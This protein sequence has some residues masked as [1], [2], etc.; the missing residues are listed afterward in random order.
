MPADTHARRFGE[1]EAVS[2]S[3]ITVELDIDA[4]HGVALG[5]GVPLRFPRVNSIV[6]IP[7]EDGAVV[8]I[9][10]AI[11]IVPSSFPKRTGLK[12]YGVVDLPF[13]SR[14][15]DITP[16]GVLK[17]TDYTEAGQ[18]QL[19]VDR[20]VLTPPT[21]GSPVL[22]PTEEELSAVL[23]GSTGGQRVEIGTAALARELRVKVDPD[24]LFGR[25]VAVLGNTGSGKSCTVSGLIRWNLD[26]ARA[27]TEAPNARFVVL[28][29]NGEYVEA[30]RDLA[31]VRVFRAEPDE[32]SSQLRVPAWL[33]NASEWSAFSEASRGVQRPLLF[34][35]LR[36]LRS[37]A[38]VPDEDPRKLSVQVHGY[39]GILRAKLNQ[40][41]PAYAE[42]PGSKNIGEQLQVMIETF[43]SYE[44]RVPEGTIKDQLTEL[45]E[46]SQAVVTNHLNN[47]GFWSAFSEPELSGVA[48]LL[49]TLRAELPAMEV[50]AGVSEDAPVPFDSAEMVAHL[51]VL[52]SG[53]HQASQFVGSF[54]LRISTMLSHIRM[55]SVVGPLSDAA[56]D[57]EEGGEGEGEA[58]ETETLEGWLSDYLA[59]SD[60]DGPS[61]VIVDLSLVPT[62]L[63]HIVAG[64]ISRVLFE[65]LQRYRRIRGFELPT[66]LVVE[67]AHHF[68]HRYAGHEHG[69]PEA[70]IVCRET[71]ETI[72]REG[73]KFGLGMVLSSQRPSEVSPTV[74]SQCNTFLLH[75]IVNDR[76]QEL[77]KRL[78]PDNLGRMLDDLPSLPT[79]HAVLLGWATAVPILM[80]VKTLPP[81]QRPR[82]SD[83]EFWATWSRTVERPVSWD[84]IAEQWRSGS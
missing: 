2:A 3:S 29:P 60:D 64:V 78:V 55:K 49:E 51:E 71:M 23:E 19:V 28:D 37:G 79:Q 68:V 21:V 53:Q 69:A 26:A 83:P 16:L 31:S 48:D 9:V 44:D 11:R 39:L 54:G 4:P 35:A 72:A 24:R 10:H 63:M 81:E 80:R 27:T 67:E 45:V 56:K 58:D 62:S 77:V 61:V 6:V 70:A 66:V 52:A 43:Q 30:F 20:G 40:G 42:F 76:D 75:R 12:E 59:S 41:P 14:L 34:Q 5:S 65:A 33:W 18:R 36:N 46:V 73:R 15:M 74:L 57:E 82:S 17:S 13:P 47:A 22:L 38:T 25:H 1:V 7:T 50:F 32:H 84:D 8:G